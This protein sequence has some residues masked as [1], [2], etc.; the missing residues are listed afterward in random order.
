MEKNP[1]APSKA[2]AYAGWL[3][4]ALTPCRPQE[5]NFKAVLESI[6]DL[7]T[8]H[9]AAMPDWLLDIFL[10]YGDPAAASYQNLPNALSS[11]DFKDTFLDESHL[12]ASFPGALMQARGLEMPVIVSCMVMWATRSKIA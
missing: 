1:F 11:I 4:L 6:R 10:G 9:H 2:F 3:L 5:N 8:E 12:R 7:M